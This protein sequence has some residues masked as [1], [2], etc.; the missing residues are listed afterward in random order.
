MTPEEKAKKNAEGQAKGC[1]TCPACHDSAWWKPFHPVTYEAGRIQADHRRPHQGDVRARFDGQKALHWLC[2]ECW[3][4]LPHAERLA[5]LDDLTAQR[6]A[7]VRMVICIPDGAGVKEC[8]VDKARFER[9]LRHLYD[10]HQ[11]VKTAAGA[12]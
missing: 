1:M 8:P 2:E 6:V 4:H 11:Q 7:R 10:L 12:A 9:E 5:H 3:Q